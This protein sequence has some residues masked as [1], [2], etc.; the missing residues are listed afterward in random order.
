[1]RISIWRQWSSNHSAAFTVMGK[2]QTIEEAQQAGDTLKN[3]LTEVARWKQKDREEKWQAFLIAQNIQHPTLADR[4]LFDDNYLSDYE[5]TEIEQQFARQ[6]N[7]TWGPTLEYAYDP[8]LAPQAV[9]IV[10]H[11][12]IVAEDFIGQETWTG[13]FPFLELLKKLGGEVAVHTEFSGSITITLRCKAP[14]ESTATQLKK[15]VRQERKISDAP[16]ISI[17]DL[18]RGQEYISEC[19]NGNVRREGLEL[20]YTYEE[21]NYGRYF[22]QLLKYLRA[23]NCTI[24]NYTFESEDIEF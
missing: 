15:Q 10:D 16:T 6:H 19:V 1:M 8:E 11:T 20:T 13:P 9:R 24:L 21:R 3:I 18:P 2:F 22:A 7:V 23:H 4:V 12:V 5:P 17:A 14:D